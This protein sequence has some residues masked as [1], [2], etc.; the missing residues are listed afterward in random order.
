MAVQETR[1]IWMTNGGTA[2][3]ILDGAHPSPILPRRNTGPVARDGLTQLTE[4]RIATRP[5]RRRTIVSFVALCVVLCVAP[6]WATGTPCSSTGQPIAVGND[7]FTFTAVRYDSPAAGQSTAY[8]EIESGSS[9]AISH[10]TFELGLACL[11]VI[12]AGEWGPSQNDLDAGAGSPTVGTDPT[13]GIEGLKFDEGFSSGETRK[14]YF[15]VDGNY[16]ADSIR[17]ASKAGPGFDEEDLCGPSLS[18]SLPSPTKTPTPTRTN[19]P[20]PTQTRTPTRTSTF[21]PTRTPT[22][23]PTSA[24]C[25]AIQ[26]I[27]FES[28]A[29]GAHLTTQ[30]PGVTASAA[31]DTAGH[32]DKAIIFNSTVPT[33]DDDD[34]GS[35]NE[36]CPGGGAGI[37]AG[38]EVGEVGENCQ[39]L[40]QVLIIAENETDGYSDGVVDVP[41]DE[42]GGG[43]ITFTFTSPVNVARVEI[44]DIEES[45]AGTVEASNG[46]GLV[47]S[48]PMLGLGDNSFQSV[49]LDAANVTTLDV[50]FPG[51]GAIPAIYYCPIPTP[52]PTQ[53]PT[54]TPTPVPGSCDLTLAKQC[55]IE[56]TPP[57]GEHCDGKVVSATFEYTGLGG[58]ASDNQQDSGKFTCSGDAGGAEPV[59]IRVTDGGSRVY[60][61]VTGVDVGD[62]IVASAANAGESDFEN[63]TFV[64]IYSGA[65]LVEESEF[66]TSCSQPVQVGDSYGSLYLR[67][68][69]TTDGGTI[70]MPPDPAP[71]DEC[72]WSIPPGPHCEGKVEGVSL[73]YLADSCTI[74]NTQEG[75]ASCSG[76]STAIDPSRIRVYAG[77][78]S[79]S[80]RHP[81][82][83]FIPYC[84]RASPAATSP[85]RARATPARASSRATSPSTSTIRTARSCKRSSS[86]LPARSRSTWAIVSAA[87]RSLLSTRPRADNSR[88]GRTSSTSTPLR[89]TV[90]AQITTSASTTT[91]SVPF[92]GAPSLRL[93]RAHP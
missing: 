23:T 46:G 32:P 69:T 6:A 8:Y 55:V 91:N 63:E 27:D 40:G 80:M 12:E 47:A 68:L 93:R 10:V 88:S 41:D 37:G 66:H 26:V 36:T 79:A 4:A 20:I 89:A 38:G 2:A 11:D 78:E 76:D 29:E 64:E 77:S 1:Q 50:I 28:V 21:T 90:P 52:T 5:Q 51:S 75:K 3:P 14:Y 59:R 15:V 71:A 16:A 84:F 48:A 62:S 49:V 56:P 83:I 19:T 25:D 85:L 53:T 7:F 74:S 18:C 57:P 17:V 86:T 34:L 92:L 61:D 22:A 54:F 30:I 31:N 9:P 72:T 13:T 82:Y 42:S 60:A 58:A 35:P 44:L 39:S 24:V 81:V 73:R 87:S 43:T 45:T 33:D 70:T 65:T 67:S